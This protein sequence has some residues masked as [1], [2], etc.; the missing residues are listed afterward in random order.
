MRCNAQTNSP[1]KEWAL[2]LRDDQDSPTWF[3]HPNSEIDVAVTPVDFNM[4]THA[5][6]RV[7]IFRSDEHAANIEKMNQVGTTEGDFVYVMG[8]P[9]GLVGG[10]N[11]VVI[12]RSGS[13]ARIRDCLA[14]VNTE[15]LIDSFVFPGNSGGPVFMKADALTISGTGGTNV[16]HL[17]GI[18]KGYVPYLDVAVSEQTRLP[19]VIFEENSGLAAVHPIDY[20]H[21]AIVEHLKSVKPTH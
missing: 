12:V 17:I 11:N 5:G 2:D 9:M 7:N 14:R 3:P 8:F 4:L 18:V 20:V 19:R 10:E 16:P 6:M 15:F 13:I 21:D 1:A